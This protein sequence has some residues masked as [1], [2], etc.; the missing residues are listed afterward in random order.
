MAYRDVD[1]VE[2]DL[3]RGTVSYEECQRIFQ[4]ED[5]VSE[6]QQVHFRCTFTAK[7]PEHHA[8]IA[9]LMSGPIARRIA[10]TLAERLKIPRP[11]MGSPAV[12]AI[13][14]GN[15][16]VAQ[17]P[18]VLPASQVVAVKNLADVDGCIN[19]ADLQ[20]GDYHIKDLLVFVQG[21]SAQRFQLS[22]LPAG[23]LPAAMPWLLSKVFNLEG[24][25]SKWG[26]AELLGTK[27]EVWLRWDQAPLPL[28]QEFRLTRADGQI[29]KRG[30]WRAKR[31]PV[32]VGHFDLP[33]PPKLPQ[34]HRRWR[35][36]VPAPIS[37]AVV[38]AACDRRLAE[39]PTAD[40]TTAR[41]AEGAGCS[42]A[43]ENRVPM[44]VAASRRPPMVTRAWE[45]QPQVQQPMKQHQQQQPQ[46]PQTQQQRSP[47]Q[48]GIATVETV[49]GPKQATAVVGLSALA[50]AVRGA[51]NG[52]LEETA[53]LTSA[54][55]LEAPPPVAE[56][57]VPTLLVQPNSGSLEAPWQQMVKRR[58]PRPRTRAQLG[59][60]L[61]KQAGR[62]LSSKNPSPTL[63]QRLKLQKVGENGLQKAGGVAAVRHQR[64]QWVALPLDDPGH[65]VSLLEEVV[66]GNV[67]SAVAGGSG[68]GVLTPLEE[69]LVGGSCPDSVLLDV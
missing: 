34:L 8:D 33:T 15:R 62:P 59:G 47:Q 68:S 51:Q 3:L 40:T 69:G 65:S 10:D 52:I 48:A 1:G 27:A 61:G 64:S 57:I 49:G 32:V 67:G 31:L 54:S 7:L 58:V 25:H 21:A 4:L 39:T 26:V 6:L 24:I 29:M 35:K 19:F 66:V 20:V 9:G 63:Q 16:V 46:Q 53:A 43:G 55:T 14:R 45:R 28:Q 2:E 60:V 5:P 12:W 13:P 42:A 11:V 22:G 18:A 41:P 23:F 36:Q 30:T 56:A 38:F 44:V 17:I 50:N 37:E